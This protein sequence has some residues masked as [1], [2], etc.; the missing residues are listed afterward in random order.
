MRPLQHHNNEAK[1]QM[2]R[3][4]HYL[5]YADPELHCH[6]QDQVLPV[7][8]ILYL[9]Q[10][11]YLYNKKQKELDYSQDYLKEVQK[12]NKLKNEFNKKINLG[13]HNLNR[14]DY[15]LNM[16]KYHNIVK[17]YSND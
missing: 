7:Q 1:N 6:H 3:G 16:K 11:K 9:F 12:E 17:K 5:D 13:Y 14:F 4:Q 15:N 8:M 2:P 10:E